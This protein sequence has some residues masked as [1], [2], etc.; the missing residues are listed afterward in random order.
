MPLGAQ[1]MSHPAQPQAPPDPH[2]FDTATSRDTEAGRLVV[3]Q[4]LFASSSPVTGLAGYAEA[5][6]RLLSQPPLKFGKTR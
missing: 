2:V 5:Q 3:P 4:Y 6:N 1:S